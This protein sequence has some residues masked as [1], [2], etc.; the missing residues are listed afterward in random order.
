MFT[1]FLLGVVLLAGLLLSA[2]WFVGAAPRDLAKMVKWLAF[3]LLVAL[4]LF[5]AFTGRLAWAFAAMPMLLV[6]F[7]RARTLFHF[8]KIFKRMSQGAAGAPTGQTSK[9]DTR[10]LYMTLDHDSGE[11]AGDVRE[12]PYAGRPLADL[13]LEELGQLLRTCWTE[14][15]QSAQV[16]E[17]YLERMRPGWRETVG[18]ED[19]RT[20]QAGGGFSGAMTEDEAWR[21]LGLEPGASASEIREAHRHLIQGMH[22]DHGG[23]SYLAAM[24]NQAKDILL[25][26]RSDA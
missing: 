5:L 23:S 12:G 26:R 4:I 8:A 9:V 19:G 14:D 25:E 13:S 22:P 7:Q 20:R 6:W 11:M 24:V 18:E 17:A 10:F 3:G 21:V 2:R 16:L 1:W 15:P